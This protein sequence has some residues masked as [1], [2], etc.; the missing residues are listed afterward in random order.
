M[1][2]ITTPF[3]PSQHLKPLPSIPENE[4]VV[5][6]APNFRKFARANQALSM[7]GA[8]TSNNMVRVKA[9]NDLT[10]A[11]VSSSLIN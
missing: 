6:A 8:F 2:I 1:K 4:V 9:C 5:L 3:H 10:R 7:R 11:E